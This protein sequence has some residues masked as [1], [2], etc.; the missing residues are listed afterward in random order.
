MAT[1]YE[2]TSDYENL[3]Q[4][5]EDPD[6]DPQILK[7]TMEAIEGEIEE[8]ADGYAMIVKE[9]EAQELALKMETDRLTNRRLAISNNITCL[10][11]GL[12]AAMRLTGKTKFKTTL[13][14]Y[15]IQKNPPSVVMDEQYI[16]NIPKD[17]LK[18]KDP[19]I[20]KK[21]ILADIKAGKDLSGIAHI[22]QTE[23]LRIR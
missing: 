17:Y 22:V 14:S 21:R 8:K 16:E 6:T 15:G 20:D 10:K 13:F 12:E 18:Y 7:D 1:L 5:A 23:S 3:L 19:D 4:L 11:R 2:L 9:L